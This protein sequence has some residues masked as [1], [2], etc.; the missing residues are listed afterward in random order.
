MPGA[1]A[2]KRG[3][4]KKKGVD[5]IEHP[6]EAE[7]NQE[8]WLRGTN[9]GKKREREESEGEPAPVAKAVKR[10]RGTKT[11]AIPSDKAATD[12]L[13]ATPDATQGGEDEVSGIEGDVDMDRT[14]TTSK[15]PEAAASVSGSEPDEAYEGE[16]AHSDAGREDDEN[17]GVEH[18]PSVSKRKAEKIAQQL[19]QGTAKL[20]SRTRISLSDFNRNRLTDDDFTSAANESEYD[21]DFLEVDSSS[22]TGSTGDGEAAKEAESESDWK[23]TII[24]RAGWRRRKGQG[25]ATVS[26]QNYDQ[27]LAHGRDDKEPRSSGALAKM[28][29]GP[30]AKPTE[31]AGS[32]KQRPGQ[33]PIDRE[34]IQHDTPARG[35]ASTAAT[36]P[37]EERFVVAAGKPR[38]RK[39]KVKATNGT[40]PSQPNAGDTASVVVMAT[41]TRTH[42]Q[43]YGP[44]VHKHAKRPSPEYFVSSDDEDD[45]IA[46]LLKPKSQP[47]PLR[48]KNATSV[49][50]MSMS[51]G[52]KRPTSSDGARHK[53]PAAGGSISSDAEDDTAN[54]KLPTKQQK[55]PTDTYLT[56]SE[57]GKSAAGIMSQR[58]AKVKSL[59]SELIAYEL[60]RALLRVNALPDKYQRPQMFLDILVEASVRLKYEDITQRLLDDTKYSRDMMKIPV[61]RMS[62]VRGP[63]YQVARDIAWEGYGLK[64]IEHDPSALKKAS[65][66]LTVDDRFISPGKLSNGKYTE[67]KADLPFCAPPIIKIIAVLFFGPNAE[68]PLADEFFTSSIKQGIE[69]EQLEIPEAMA[70]FVATMAGAAIREGIDGARRPL[71]N[72]QGFIATAQDSRYAGHLNTLQRLT[73]M[74]RHKILGYMYKTAK[75]YYVKGPADQPATSTFVNPATAG[76]N[77]QL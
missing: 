25:A 49:E 73:T 6:T 56:Y 62:S 45:G 35:H 14:G 47:K 18:E 11:N 41:K 16:E 23:A 69:S 50:P 20:V 59:F 68:I 70:A 57:D 40:D 21:A 8:A 9:Q 10:G 33:Q 32:P 66:V 13:S 37:T 36:L 72:G 64:E 22:T 44:T 31:H 2:N 71:K 1:P 19:E 55:W 48:G 5:V 38:R 65:R 39:E 60:P 7:V 4:A 75:A 51:D 74:G 26:E 58:S 43:I 67:F 77:I 42:Q 30:T 46:A 3:R 63:L 15:K 27:A 29:A 76:M 53:L 12:D 28:H 17:F 52:V 24:H 54:L 61:D 34:G